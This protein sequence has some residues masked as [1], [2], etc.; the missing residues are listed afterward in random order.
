MSI[1]NKIKKIKVTDVKV[2]Y[3][4]TVPH[5]TENIGTLKYYF[6]PAIQVE[7]E[8]G[9]SLEEVYEAIH[10][11]VASLVRKKIKKDIERLNG[12]R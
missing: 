10:N 9:I 5:P 8:E 2:G 3:G 6:E 7:F 1:N 11:K 12:Q 4:E